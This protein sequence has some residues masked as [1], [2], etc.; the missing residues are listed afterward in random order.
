MYLATT[1]QGLEK[2][3]EKETKGKSYIKTKIIYTRKK[4]LKSA[5]YWFE[6][7]KKFKFKDEKEIYSKIKNLKIKKPIRIECI[8]KGNHN[9][10]S[11]DV[12]NSISKI[13]K[14]DYKNPKDILVIDIL[15]DYCFIG[16]EINTYK[17]FYKLRS[18]RDSLNPIICYSLLKIAG[19]NKNNS[20]LDPFCSDGSILIEAGLSGCKKLY[21]FNKDIKNASIN[22]KIAKVGIT[23]KTENIDWLDTI[24]KKDA[25]D[26]I[27]SSVPFISKRSNEEEIKKNLRE[28]FYQAKFILKNKMVLISQKT[29]LLE[30]YAEELGF[31]IKKETEIKSGDI[32]YKVLSFKKVI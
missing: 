19:L 20:V 17:R 3:A 1:L 21:G 31:K 14:T 13:F 22:S 23:F 12:R 16:K 30:K 24:F 25:I 2:I 6:L 9:F 4:E 27:I 26:F 18:N 7:L 15:D 29:D 8:R 10:N 11:Q 5:L 32:F 28:L